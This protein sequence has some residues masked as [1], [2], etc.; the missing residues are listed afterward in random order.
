MKY[1]KNSEKD[2]KESKDFA[3]THMAFSQQTNMD[4][5]HSFPSTD[6]AVINFEQKKN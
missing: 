4:Q 6:F 3:E 2:S 1:F 5:S